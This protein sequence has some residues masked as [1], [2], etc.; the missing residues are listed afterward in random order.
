VT[1]TINRLTRAKEI[2]NPAH[3]VRELPRVYTMA[4]ILSVTEPNV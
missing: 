2:P 4:L 3:Q 1:L